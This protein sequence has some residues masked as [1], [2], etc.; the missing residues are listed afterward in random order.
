MS[1]MLMHAKRALQEQP[2]SMFL[3]A[4][5]VE[6]GAE[7]AEAHIRIR[8]ELKQQNG[9][10]HGGVISYLADT[11]LGFA[12]GSALGS[13]VVTS[14]FKVNFLRPATGYK[15]IARATALY[16][17]RS[18]AVCRCDVFTVLDDQERLCATAQGTISTLGNTRTEQS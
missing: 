15:L 4:E 16:V 13:W 18:Q 17:G 11:A 1:T 2:F 8:N 14:E 9:F 12:G 3:G 5:I 10:V 6:C 7:G